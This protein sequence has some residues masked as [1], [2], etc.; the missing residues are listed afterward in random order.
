MAAWKNTFV[1]ERLTTI[2]TKLTK[3]VALVVCFACGRYGDFS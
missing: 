1:S 3:C 2:Q